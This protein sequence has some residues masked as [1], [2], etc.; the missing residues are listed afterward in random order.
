MNKK[1]GICVIVANGVYDGYVHVMYSND[2]ITF[3]ADEMTGIWE[4]D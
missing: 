2:K 4:I 1:V 3:K